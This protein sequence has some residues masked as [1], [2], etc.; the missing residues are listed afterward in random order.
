M[1]TRKII[2][3]LIDNPHYW[4]LPLRERLQLIFRLSLC[5]GKKVCSVPVKI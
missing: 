4:L 5:Y 2:S 3:I 1:Q